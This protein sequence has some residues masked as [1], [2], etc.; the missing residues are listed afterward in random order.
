MPYVNTAS[1]EDAPG[2]ALQPPV[3]PQPVLLPQ[4]L[5]V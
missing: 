2:D 3:Q 4:L 1:P 5:H